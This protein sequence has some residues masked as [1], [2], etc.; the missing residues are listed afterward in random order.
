MHLCNEW[1]QTNI[2]NVLECLLKVISRTWK[3]TWETHYTTWEIDIAPSSSYYNSWWYH[4]NVL[5]LRSF[6]I[7]RK[8]SFY[9]DQVKLSRSNRFGAMQENVKWCEYW[10]GEI[11]LFFETFKL[12]KYIFYSFHMISSLKAT[13]HFLNTKWAVNELYKLNL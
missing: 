5:P 10:F 6:K 2:L 3:Q 9:L 1:Y 13:Q 7:P 11:L 12:F 4:Q 8:L